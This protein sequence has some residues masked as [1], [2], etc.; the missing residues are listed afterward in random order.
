MEDT[1]PHTANQGMD[2]PFYSF[3]L[4]PGY[5][6]LLGHIKTH[7]AHISDLQQMPT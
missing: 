2:H 5:F 7:L 4:V 6:Q 1:A 3:N